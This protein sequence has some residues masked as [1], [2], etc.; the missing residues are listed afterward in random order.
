MAD[1]ARELEAIV[2]RGRS[3][4]IRDEES[5][6]RSLVR[7]VEALQDAIAAALATWPT[8]GVPAN[9][10]AWL[11]TAARNRVRVAQRLHA[12]VAQAAPRLAEVDLET[13]NLNTIAA[14]L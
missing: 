6:R 1:L 8:D 12:V 4:K 13:R 3:G 5:H 10:A 2:R 7:S 14:D 9:P 11:A